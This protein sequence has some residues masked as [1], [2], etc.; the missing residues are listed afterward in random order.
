MDKWEGI[1]EGIVASAIGLAVVF[2]VGVFVRQ[3]QQ[4]IDLRANQRADTIAG[5]MMDVQVA[6]GCKMVDGI[7]GGETTRLVNAAVKLEQEVQFNKYAEVYMTP[8]GAPNEGS[9]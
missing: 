1:K 4:I 7:I 8:S 9:E 5:Q 6:V 2:L 3:R